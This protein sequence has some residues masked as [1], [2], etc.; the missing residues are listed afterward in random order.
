MMIDAFVP[1]VFCASLV[2]AAGLVKTQ[3]LHGRLTFDSTVGVQKLHTTPTPR[4]GG[5]AVACGAVVGWAALDGERAAM[6]ATLCL[7]MVPAFASG[8]LEDLTKRVG[9]AVR[10]AAT[11]LSGALVALAFG[12]TAA[13]PLVV[14]AVA[15]GGMANAVNIIDGV[16]GLASGTGIAVSLA[17]AVIAVRV[18]DPTLV[19]VSLALA[20]SLAGFFA[21][22]FPRGRLFLGDAGAYATG[23]LLA[24]IAIALPARHVALSPLVGL[25][26]LAYPLIETLVSIVRRLGR[27]GAS[28][29]RADRLH[30]HSLVYRSE[31]RRVAR[32]LGAPRAQNAL[33]A[34]IVGV[35]PATSAAWAALA[36]MH[37]GAC[38]L[39]LATLTSAYWVVYRRALR[40]RRL[41][42]IG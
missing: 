38:L 40:F 29:G 27:R 41:A 10:L 6:W 32:A 30:L 16:H 25:L 39:G 14:T 42:P 17:F 31:A 1:V 13:L 4:I 23:G 28:P 8:L 37:T 7:C 21:L 22:N 24:A 33:T 11:L 2:V 20:A 3:A 35:L 36:C 5:L 19:A 34:V 18:E 26:A 15:V 9:V 12:P